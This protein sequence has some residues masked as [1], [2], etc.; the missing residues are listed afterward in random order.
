MTLMRVRR[1][2]ARRGES[3]GQDRGKR[4]AR[5]AWV[6]VKGRQVKSRRKPRRVHPSRR[7]LFPRPSPGSAPR[8]RARP[9]L[10]RVFVEYN[11]DGGELQ[12][13]V[14]LIVISLNASF[15]YHRLD[16]KAGRAARRAAR[17]RPSSSI[18]V[19]ARRRASDVAHVGRRGRTRIASRL[20]SRAGGGSHGGRGRL[21]RRIPATCDEPGRDIP[22]GRTGGRR[23]QL[24][25]DHDA[26]IADAMIHA[27]AEETLRA[28]AFA[29]FY[30][31]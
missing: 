17:R 27:R 29:K 9:D 6:S 16:Y 8:K 20:K 24:P 21:G 13:R 14:S 2:G 4:G 25:G 5:A 15:T 30:R 23:L 10:P 26:R 7:T 3:I 31:R 19:E 1:G 11:T 12:L 28:G 22:W 18:G